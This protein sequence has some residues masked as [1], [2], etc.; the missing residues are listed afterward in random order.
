[1]KYI[2]AKNN[3]ISSLEKTLPPEFASPIRP[4]KQAERKSEILS[5]QRQKNHEKGKS[6]EDA[7]ANFLK[8]KGYIILERNW[9]FHKNEIDIIAL[10][11]SYL[12]FVE[13]KARKS[14]QHG[15]GYE[16]VDKKK[17]QLIKKVAEAYLI[18]TCRNL[19]ETPCRFDVVSID[20][21]NISMF[22]NAF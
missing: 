2:K 3:E 17:Q 12:V 4:S 22:K 1:M 11:G 20:G 19:N 21:G 14:G 9:R 6:S 10:D 16:A 7:A 15:Y 8:D 5:E 13:V 18:F